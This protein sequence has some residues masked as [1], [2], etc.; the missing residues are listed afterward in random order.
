[1]SHCCPTEFS[2]KDLYQST[3]MLLAARPDAVAAYRLQRDVLRLDETA[4]EMQRLRAAARQSGWVR[5]VEAT[6]LEDGSWGR[7][8]T[9]DSRI[10]PVFRT[11]EEALH[12]ALALGLDIHD[13]VLQRAEAYILRVMNGEITISDPPEKNDRVPLG[14]QLMTGGWLARLDSGHPEMER[15]WRYW[16]DVARRAFASGRYSQTD[17]E[18]AYPTLS[19]VKVPKG[20]LRSQYALW[21]LAARP[22]PADLD[23]EVTNWIWNRPDGIYYMGVCL[24]DW[25]QEQA[26]IW[27]RSMD[28]LSGF[29]SWREVAMPALN[30]LWRQRDESG[31]WNFGP[32][33]AHCV[34]F[35]LSENWRTRARCQTDFSTRVLGLLRKVFD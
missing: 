31:R 10:K 25:Q 13:E 22:L 12:R 28:L 4:P 8:H 5:Q 27:F 21:M 17:E 26:S 24:N 23:A 14:I 29:S 15:H 19:G 6:Q 1:M 11:S 7:F 35:P 9:Q 33:L 32:Q 34:E 20:F 30:E 3:E 2:L 18:T 16:F